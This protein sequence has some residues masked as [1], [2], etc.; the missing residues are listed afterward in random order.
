[1]KKYLVLIFAIIIIATLVIVG[2]VLY[3]PTSNKERV[4]TYSGEGFGGDFTI[5]LRDDNTASFYEG[6]LSS[7]ISEGKWRIE[8]NMLIISDDT[9]TNKF[10]MEEKTLTFI[11]DGSTNFPY[12]E[13]KDGEKFNLN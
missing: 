12:V 9:F 7:Y 3:K 10:K 8:D 2:I 6:Y 11:E 13:V 5:T 4:Y 1:M